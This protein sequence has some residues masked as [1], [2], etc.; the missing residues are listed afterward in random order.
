MVKKKLTSVLGGG[1]GKK[2]VENMESSFIFSLSNH[3]SLFQQ[4]GFCKGQKSCIEFVTI[5]KASIDAGMLY[6][7]LL[8]TKKLSSFYALTDGQKNLI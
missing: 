4:V 8:A 2:L 6:Y 7:F 3:T 1:S 5:D